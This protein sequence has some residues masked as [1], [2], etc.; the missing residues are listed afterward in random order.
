MSSRAVLAVLLVVVAGL[1]VGAA[2]SLSEGTAETLPCHAVVD[3]GVLPS[4]ARTG[5][6]DPRPK[7]PHTIG[8]RGQLAALIFGYP[9]RAQPAKNRSNKILW[10]AREPLSLGG[11]DLR[12]RAQRMRGTHNVA[13]AVTRVVMGGPGPSLV[14]LPR[15][16][17]WRVEARWAGHHDQLDL[18]YR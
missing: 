11:G 6:S 10:V 14:D 18:R 12:L 4:W 1:A 2:T 3:H 15:A 7:L 13:R 8:D 16:G 17:C 5:F 9:L